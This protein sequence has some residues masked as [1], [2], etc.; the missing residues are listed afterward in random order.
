MFIS[1]QERIISIN[2]NK[3]ARSYA[4]NLCK[5]IFKRLGTLNTHKLIHLGVKSHVCPICGKG[6]TYRHTLNIHLR[7]H[8]GE[9]P[10][11]CGIWVRLFP[12]LTALI[13]EYTLGWISIPAEYAVRLLPKP[14]PS[15][16]IWE[17]IQIKN[18]IFVPSVVKLFLNPTFSKLMRIHSEKKHICEFCSK[19]FNQSNHFKSH[20][21]IHNEQKYTCAVCSK[22]FNRSNDLKLHIS[23]HTGEKK[24]VYSVCSN[25]FVRHYSLKMHIRTHTTDKPYCCEVCGRSFSANIALTF[26]KRDHGE[27]YYI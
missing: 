14:W 25:A 2:I 23:Q 6:F 5:K 11:T 1:R 20:M 26:H 16:S 10:N 17:Y 3:S 27:Q 15:N 8:T 18:R 21:S 13:W 24:H 22:N 4:C 7:M 9:K 12:C 19:S